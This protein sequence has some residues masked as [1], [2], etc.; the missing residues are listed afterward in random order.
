MTFLIPYHALRSGMGFGHQNL[1]FN[2]CRVRWHLVYEKDD[3][4]PWDIAHFFY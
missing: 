3:S 2:G 4:L 1:R